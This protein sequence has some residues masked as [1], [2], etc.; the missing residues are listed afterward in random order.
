MSNRIPRL[1]R[2]DAEY[3]PS[4]SVQPRAGAPRSVSPNANRRPG[5]QL[6]R[7]IGLGGPP[8]GPPG[9]CYSRGA[10]VTGNSSRQVPT[11]PGSVPP[12]ADERSALLAFLAQQRH[13]LRIAAHGLTDEQ[14]RQAPTAGSLTIG[15]LIKH[16]AK[17]ERYW[18]TLALQ[19]PDEE[20]D[21]YEDTFGLRP[22][23]TLA[24]VLALYAE[25]ATETERAIR[26]ISDL[27]QAVPVPRDVPW[28]PQDVEAWSV[29]WVL[30]HL[31]EETARHAGHA[32]I[33]REALDGATAFPLM[34]AAEGWPA[35]PWLQPW[36]PRTGTVSGD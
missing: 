8:V 20:T 13:V 27:G 26:A 6:T 35:S 34:A 2:N 22:D 25:V 33:V 16:V 18:L 10:P 1:A 7:R 5:R 29:R 19:Q 24:G 15:G 17:T 28:F 32:D 21:S 14:A 31:I 11:V 12:V 3:Q 9:R 30:L 36:E 4:R 23:E